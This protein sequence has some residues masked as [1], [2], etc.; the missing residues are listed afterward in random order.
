MTM[1]GLRVRLLEQVVGIV[2]RLML[3]LG[4]RLSLGITVVLGAALR[5]GDGDLDV[6]LT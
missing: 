6:W 1:L 2:V 5:L 3:P 4:E